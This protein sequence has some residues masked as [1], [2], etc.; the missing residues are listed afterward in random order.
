MDQPWNPAVLEQRIGR[1]HRLPEPET[2]Q[3]IVE[4]FGA[5]TKRE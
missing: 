1:V 5:L 4:L 3:K 2:M